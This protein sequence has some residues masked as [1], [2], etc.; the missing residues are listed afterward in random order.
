MND[1]DKAQ[2][3]EVTAFHILRVADGYVIGGDK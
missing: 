3:H 1:K 2:W